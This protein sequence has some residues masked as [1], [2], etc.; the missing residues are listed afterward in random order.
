MTRFACALFAFVIAAAFSGTRV[1]EPTL[2]SVGAATAA[3]TTPAMPTDVGMIRGDQA[4]GILR[5]VEDDGTRSRHHH[6]SGIA[7][8]A[9]AV[10]ELRHLTGRGTLNHVRTAADGERTRTYDANAPPVVA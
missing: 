2:F 7:A 10:L 4:A 6:S 9:N 5:L 8:S 3:R 1:R